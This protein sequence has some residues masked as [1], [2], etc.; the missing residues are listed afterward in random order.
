MAQRTI[1]TV[2]L[3]GGVRAVVYFNDDNFN[4]F[5]KALN[6]KTDAAKTIKSRVMSQIYR[7]AV[8]EIWRVY[9]TVTFGERLRPPVTSGTFGNDVTRSIWVQPQLGVMTVTSH[10]PYAKYFMRNRQPHRPPFSKITSWA[11]EKYG[12]TRSEA[13]AIAYGVITKL[14][15][16]G[17]SAQPVLTRAL[18]AG[19]R[20]R[21]IVRDEFEQ[22]AAKTM[23]AK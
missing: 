2:V 20:F 4:R 12:V 17:S 11:M 23:R 15:E 18:G 3:D 1:K 13:G 10:T 19:S 22:A 21:A 14:E 9:N 7:E 6:S 16:E 5:R 8:N